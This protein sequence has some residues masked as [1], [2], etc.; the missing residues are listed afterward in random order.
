[1][2]LRAAILTYVALMVL[3]AITVAST[4]VPLGVG[5]SLINLVVALA[6]AVLIG[7]VFMHLRR[8]APLV[9]LCVVVLVLWIGLMYGLTF[10]DYATR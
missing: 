9:V 1:M 10:N 6:K 2:T 8:A 4:F 5:N 7:L 3:L